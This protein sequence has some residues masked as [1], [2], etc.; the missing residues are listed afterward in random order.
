MGLKPLSIRK[1][2][3]QTEDVFE[4]VAVIS[5]RA[6]QIIR[7]RQLDQTM[8][9]NIEDDYE[10]FDEFEEIVPEDYVEI[11]KPTKAA[12]D[13]FIDGKLEWGKS[14]EFGE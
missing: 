7:N 5:E 2:E 14:V 3:S 10:T 1:M 11:D 8:K 13:E 9:E 6:R 4:A 12:T